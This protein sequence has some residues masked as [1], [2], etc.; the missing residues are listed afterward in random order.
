[1]LKRMKY[2]L[3]LP[4]TAIVSCG[5]STSYLVEGDKYVSVNF[6][7]NYYTHWDDELKS[8]HKNDPVN[9]TEESYVHSY[10]Y[11]GGTKLVDLEIVD[12]NFIDNDPIME[13][14]GSEFRMGDIDE[15]FRYGYQSKMFDGQMVCGAQNGKDG[16]NDPIDY[17]YEKGRVQIKQTGFSIRFSKESNE[18]QYFAMQFKASTDYKR[19]WYLINGHTYGKQN[20]SDLKHQSNVKLKITL[21]TKT[22]TEIVGYP[23]TLD[24]EFEGKTTNDG[25]FYKFIAFDLQKYKLTRLI[26]VSIDFTVNS[27]DLIEYNLSKH[28]PVSY[29]EDYALFLYEMFFPYTSWN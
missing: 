24:V 26:G 15:S 9:V 17:S 13:V 4:L 20:P 7:E 28:A 3:L 10:S 21:Y 19:D 2:L 18:L 8:A 12:P 23:F 14:Y 1:M 11:S 6:K 25:S 22:N 16:I 29:E 27:D 5:Y